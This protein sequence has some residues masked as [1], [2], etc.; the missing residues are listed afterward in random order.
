MQIYNSLS[1]K[2]ENFSPLVG[3]DVKMY[4]CGVT[5]Y[6]RS[7]IGH[8]RSLY[9]FDVIRRYLKFRGF[10]VTF[11]RNITD[12][13]DKIIDRANETKRPARDV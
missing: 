12:I 13:D 10:N 1:G 9:I 3:N 7:H 2:K 4:T 6:D 11:V 8:A 5:V